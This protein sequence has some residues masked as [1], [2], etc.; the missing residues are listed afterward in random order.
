[1]RCPDCQHENAAGSKFCESCGAAQAGGCDSCGA[2]V[3]ASARFCNQCGATQS[4]AALSGAAA[5]DRGAPRDYTPRHLADRILTSR[6]ALMGERKQVTILFADVKGSMVLAEELDPER[7]HDILDRF[8]EILASGIHRFEGTVNQYTGDGVMALFG[9]PLAHEDHAQRACFAA[10]H[11]QREL[12]IFADELRLEG[13]NLSV[14]QGLNSGDV[15]VGKIGDDLRMDY[16]AQG[17]TVGLA[18]RAEGL[19]EA[20]SA[21]LTGHTARLVEGYFELRSLG[22]PQLRGVSE[23]VELFELLGLGPLR[24]RLDVSRASGFTRFVGRSSELAQLETALARA[25][26]GEGAV[27][28]VVGEAGVGKSRLCQTFAEQARGRGVAVYEAHCPAHGQTVPFAAI[29]QILRANYGI[30]DHDDPNIIVGSEFLS[31]RFADSAKLG[32]DCCLAEALVGTDR[33]HLA[34]EQAVLTGRID[35]IARA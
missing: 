3:S 13:V 22:R 21:L 17:H 35:E 29:L 11:L 1:M 25:E 23:S 16:T 10:L 26:S 18:Q 5:P 19:A 8:F 32:K 34:R 7:W 15:V 24:T 9:A 2:P 27:V 33:I 14:R 6:A 20:G 4:E 31:R 12:R 30:G 28:G